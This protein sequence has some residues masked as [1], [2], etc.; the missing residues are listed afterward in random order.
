[1][2]RQTIA[3]A[4][5]D[6]LDEDGLDA[7][8]LRKLATR[9]GVKSPALYWHFTNKHELLDEMARLL[10]SAQP[11]SPLAAEE[12][13]DTWML[14]FA[15]NR[16]QVLLSRRDGARLVVGS[17]GTE[18]TITALDAALAGLLERGF[19]AVQALRGLTTINAFVLGFVQEE[20][21][22]TQR[23]AETGERRP[24]D[25]LVEQRDQLLRHTPALAEAIASG[26]DPGGTAAFEDGLRVIVSGIAA[27][28]GLPVSGTAPSGT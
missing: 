9:L 26:G 23:H 3:A 20:Q 17:R 25:T 19:T 24:E 11:P 13:W 1:M 14:R 16:R 27:V 2:N 28:V 6:L 18:E 5:L 7:L 12:G 4:A 15:R 21:A 10:V 8:S 22:D